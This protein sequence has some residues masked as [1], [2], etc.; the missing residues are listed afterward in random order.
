MSVGFIAANPQDRAF[1]LRQLP[2]RRH[3]FVGHSEQLD[4]FGQQRIACLREHRGL[5]AAIEQQLAQISH[6]A[7]VVGMPISERKLFL[8]FLAVR[9]AFAA[10]AR[11]SFTVAVLRRN[12]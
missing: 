1:P 9:M 8:L 12:E 6:A 2:D 4:R 7:V 10:K 11:G 5:R 3:C